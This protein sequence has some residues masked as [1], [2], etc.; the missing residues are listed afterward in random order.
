MTGRYHENDSLS[1]NESYPK[2]RKRKVKRRGQ[3]KP[4]FLNQDSSQIIDKNSK[5]YLRLTSKR[6][7]EFPNDLRVKYDILEEIDLDDNKLI[8]CNIRK[9]VPKLKVLSVRFNKLTSFPTFEYDINHSSFDSIPTLNELNLSCNLISSFDGNVFYMQEFSML[10][11]LNLSNNGLL[12]LPPDIGN[13]MN[14]EKL[15]LQNNQLTELPERII[16]LKNLKYFNVRG[17]LLKTP[18]QDAV[19]NGGFEVVRI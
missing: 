7:Q 17:N 2:D 19:D 15:C 9:P 5:K 10:S 6:F 3:L 16:N 18:L 4:G 11:I 1:H 12:L 13:L 8:R 14:L